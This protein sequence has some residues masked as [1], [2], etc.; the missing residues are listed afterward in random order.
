MP[1]DDNKIKNMFGTLHTKLDTL[2]TERDGIYK[3]LERLEEIEKDNDG[4]VKMDTGTK[5]IMSTS[6]RQEIYNAIVAEFD[7]LPA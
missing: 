3:L 6:R 4:N 1:V 5:A 2:T 7:A